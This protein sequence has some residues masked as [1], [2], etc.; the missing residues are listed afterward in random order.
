VGMESALSAWDCARITDA[1]DHSLE[2]QSILV[3]SLVN[4]KMTTTSARKLAT[5]KS[6]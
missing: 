4:A 6:D 1:P 2:R 3:Q 5:V